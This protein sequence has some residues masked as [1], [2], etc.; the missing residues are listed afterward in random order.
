MDTIVEESKKIENYV[1][2][3]NDSQELINSVKN[4]YSRR[5]KVNLEDDEILSLLGSQSGFAELSLSLV[6]SG[7]VVLTPDPGYPIFTIGPYLAGAKTS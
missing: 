5:Y 2:A 1:Y 6:N 7:D 4:W 3:I